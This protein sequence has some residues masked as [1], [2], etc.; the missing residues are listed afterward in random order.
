MKFEPSHASSSELTEEE[1]RYLG[2]DLSPRESSV[3]DDERH[4]RF[5]ASVMTE[6]SSALR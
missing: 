4:H 6:R 3:Q 5:V 1:K 2:F